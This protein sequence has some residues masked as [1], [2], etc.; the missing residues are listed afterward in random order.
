MFSHI[1]FSGG[2]LKGVVYLGVIKYL[3]EHN[4][5][6][7]IKH[8]HG[9]SIGAFMA[10]TFVLGLPIDE[11]YKYFAVYLT[12]ENLTNFPPIRL[13]SVIQKAGIDMGD[14]LYAPIDHLLTMAGLSPNITFAELA[15]AT[16]KDLV[17][18]AAELSKGTPFLFS[19]DN[20]PNVSVKLAV[21]ASM[22]IPCIMPP[23]QINGKW[24]ADGVLVNNIPVPDDI[25]PKH[26]LLV[27]IHESDELIISTPPNLMN[28]IQASMNCWF[29]T[30]SSPTMYSR[31]KQDAIVIDNVPIG[32]LPFKY[33]NNARI[34]L[35][36]KK[37][38]LGAAFKCGYEKTK[39]WVGCRLDKLSNDRKL[40]Q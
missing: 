39:E 12:H 4:L 10:L 37:E 29:N 2:G 25:Q 35:A 27:I 19:V 33:T 14:R 40:K 22:S 36:V 38:E 21:V 11:V 34:S 13:L 23:V 7:Y 18:C 20:S 6:S 17:I 32:T 16:G 15:K 1:V 26:V 28:I 3:Q 8:A 24:Y 9:T 31:Y 30:M 5:T